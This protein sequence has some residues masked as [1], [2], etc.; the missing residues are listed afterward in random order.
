M[1]RRRC[2]REP[3]PCTGHVGD[4]LINN[5]T[6]SAV[7]DRFREGDAAAIET[8]YERYADRLYSYCFRQTGSYT[9]AQDLASTVWLEAWRTRKRPKPHDSG[10]LGP[11]LFG[12]A[13]NVIRNSQRS[14]R[15]HRAA[16]ARLAA[17]IA[18]P[19]HADRICGRLDD[20]QRMR[21]VLSSVRALPDHERDVLALVVWGEL[22]HAEVAAALG[23]SVGTVKSRL[24]RA[25]ARL[26]AS[27]R[28][29]ETAT[30]TTTTH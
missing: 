17:P 4:V 21:T 18:E 28:P 16:L 1:R 25:R 30:S 5:A 12:I 19:D 6:D 26:S 15:R 13:R 22:S 29:P 2:G 23:S 11:W 10:S 27:S 8:L 14:Q 3:L 9:L 20:E 7:W 24:S